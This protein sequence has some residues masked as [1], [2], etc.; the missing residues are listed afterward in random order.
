MNEEK[1]MEVLVAC[2]GEHANAEKALKLIYENE[3]N[4]NCA[5]NK[6]GYTPL[7]LA[8]SNDKLDTVVKPLIALGADINQVDTN[9]WSALMHTCM[10]LRVEQ[11]LVLIDEGANL[12][13]VGKWNL[14]SGSETALDI[15]ERGGYTGN[16]KDERAMELANAIRGRG[17][18]KARDVK[19]RGGNRKRKTRKARKGRKGTRRG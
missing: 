13:L 4:L 9:K 1:C 18:L 11:A 7:M 8:V 14:I 5:T 15:V 10:N 12:N 19:K 2:Y 3:N 17:G 6:S 16:P